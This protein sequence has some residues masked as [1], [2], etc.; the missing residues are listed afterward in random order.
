MTRSQK[1]ILFGTLLLAFLLF[2]LRSRK[3]VRVERGNF[4]VN[5]GEVGGLED[6]GIILQADGFDW[7]GGDCACEMI[8]FDPGDIDLAPPYFG[9]VASFVAAQF[10]PSPAL[11]INPLPA[12]VPFVSSI[13][14]PAPALP[15]V[16]RAA[17][18][19]Y[20]AVNLRPGDTW[21][22]K[23]GTGTV[24]KSSIGA[25]A[26]RLS[27]GTNLALGLSNRAFVQENIFSPNGPI[28]F[29]GKRYY[30]SDPV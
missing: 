22:T 19:T 16:P 2:A 14:P 7:M 8:L 27:D 21:V 18:L 25:L 15:P 17:T 6:E 24:P 28:L 23:K 30:R 1:T 12:P 29:N 9:Q 4:N 13:M 26:W 3:T 20:R 10:T 11:A 5:I